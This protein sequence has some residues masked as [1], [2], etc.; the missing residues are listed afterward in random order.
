MVVGF[1]ILRFDYSVLSMYADRDLQELPT[2]DMLA[3]IKKI[4]GYRVSLDNLA[5]A[6]L[7]AKK[8]AD[9][10]QAL[11]WWKEGKVDEIAKYCRQDVAVTRD[12]YLHGQE[13]GYLLFT[14]KAGQVVRVKVGW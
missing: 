3:E 1:N 7:G 6:T 13:H 10:L 5:Q 8:S 11:R 4:L 12:L 14:N 2:L 9:G